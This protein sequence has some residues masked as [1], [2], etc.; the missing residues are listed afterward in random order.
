MSGDIL[1]EIF[2]KKGE[3][4]YLSFSGHVA[5]RFKPL[6]FNRTLY[7]YDPAT[8]L[9]SEDSGTIEE[10]T[11]SI[12]EDAVCGSLMS[13]KTPFAPI[14][15]EALNRAYHHHVIPGKSSPFNKFN[16]IPVNNGVLVFDQTGKVSLTPY[17]PAMRF[18]HKLRINYRPEADPGPIDEIL[19]QWV[20]EEDVNILYQLAA[21]SLIQGLPG[22]EPNKKAYLIQGETNGGKS[23][24]LNLLE[25][26]FGKENISGVSLDELPARFNKSSIAGKFLN[27]A[28]DIQSVSIKN[29]ENFK[30]I[31]GRRSHEI[32]EKFKPRYVDDIH[33]VF[34][35]TC[36]R[37]PII[38]GVAETDDAFWSRWYLV[39]FPRTFPVIPGWHDEHFT[40]ANI[41]GFFSQVVNTAAVMLQNGGKLLVPCD[42]SDVKYRWQ[43]EASPIIEFLEEQTDRGTSFSVDKDGLFEAFWRWVEAVEESEA[44]KLDRRRRSPQTKTALSQALI[45]QGIEPSQMGRNKTGVYKGIRLKLNSP[46]LSRKETENSVLV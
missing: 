10:W 14:K 24:F 40:E 5:Q 9:Y 31:T 27:V 22:H 17:E 33:A 39:R 29:V 7:T 41:E 20:D 12:L 44:D 13:C 2:D 21:Q 16:G 42:L 11:Q 26:V 8:S 1:D 18:T 28:D 35:Y 23:T 4:D 19:R 36:N 45:R 34:C 32:E 38:E 6:T 46:Y 37:P 30:A 25:A 3:F 15:K 43:H